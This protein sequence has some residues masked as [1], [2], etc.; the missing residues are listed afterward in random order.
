MREVLFLNIALYI[1]KYIYMYKMLR[2]V[3]IQGS[4]HSGLEE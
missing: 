2:Y 4:A 3:S 1:G